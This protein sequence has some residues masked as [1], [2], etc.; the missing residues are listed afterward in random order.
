MIINL[1]L[2]GNELLLFAIIYGFSQDEKSQYKGS[3]SYLQEILKITRPTV[4]KCIKNLV[5]KDLIIKESIKIG[6]VRH[7]NYQV[8]F[9]VVNSFNQ[10][11][12]IHL[13]HIYKD[14]IK[15]KKTT[16][17]RKIPSKSKLPKYYAKY[18]FFTAE[19]KKLWFV[20]FLPLKKRK[21]ASL[22]DRA[23]KRALNKVQEYSNGDYENALQIL[24]RSVDGGWT[25]LYPLNGQRKKNNS[26]THN[27]K[28]NERQQFT[29]GIEVD[30]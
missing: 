17:K 13:P 9:E 19:F 15:K 26:G 7:N 5:E 2:S 11:S 1:A 24:T 20:E 22:E 27:H 18:S 4:I 25:D 21:G 28:S 30:N 14:N 23:N 16:K 8:N 3:L 12:K 29:D 10:P 6:K